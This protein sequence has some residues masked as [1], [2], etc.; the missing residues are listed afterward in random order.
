FTPPFAQNSIAGA[1]CV[2]LG[3]MLVCALLGV[4]TEK[5][6]YRPLRSRPRLTVLITAIGVSIFLEYAGQFV[7]GAN[8]QYFPQLLYFPPLD[9]TASFSLASHNLSLTNLDV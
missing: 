9:K 5:I 8:P 2:L 6:A 1:I 4:L 7:F 3:A